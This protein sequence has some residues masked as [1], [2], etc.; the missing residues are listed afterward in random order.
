MTESVEF[1]GQEKRGRAVPLVTGAGA[2]RNATCLRSAVGLGAHASE[3]NR[4]SDGGL[5]ERLRHR[6]G[7]GVD[8]LPTRTVG[9]HDAT[10][11][12]RA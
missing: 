2:G 11:A 1:G 9:G 12:G 3:C 5:D 7:D 8:R 4:R 10:D 6:S